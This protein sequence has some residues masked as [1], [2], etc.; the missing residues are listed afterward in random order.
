MHLDIYT[1]SLQ[2]QNQMNASFGLFGVGNKRKG[3]HVYL[4]ISKN[5]SMHIFLQDW[6]NVEKK[7]DWLSVSNFLLFLCIPITPSKQN[8]T[9][10]VLSKLGTHIYWLFP[11]ISFMHLSLFDAIS[12]SAGFV[13]QLSTKLILWK[14]LKIFEK[15]SRYFYIRNILLEETHCFDTGTETNIY[16]IDAYVYTCSELLLLVFKIFVEIF[17]GAKKNPQQHHKISV[18][19]EGLIYIYLLNR[20][21]LFRVVPK[22]YTCRSIEK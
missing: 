3:V 7:I 6:N 5:I 20:F 22:R 21:V 8:S 11:Y 10:D 16:R 12:I 19:R 13:G 1:Y 2:T 14:K 15:K 18:C 4:K 9:N 17:K